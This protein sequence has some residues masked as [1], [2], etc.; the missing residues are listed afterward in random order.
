MILKQRN[1]GGKKGKKITNKTRREERMILYF[2]RLIN[3]KTP[4]ITANLSG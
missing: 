2:N 4:A 1:E 3:N